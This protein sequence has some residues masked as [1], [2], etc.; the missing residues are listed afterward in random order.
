MNPHFLFRSNILNASTLGVSLVVMSSEEVGKTGIV[1]NIMR[2]NEM[3][4]DT[5]SDTQFLH[6]SGQPG[7]LLALRTQWICLLVVT[8]G[9]L[10]KGH[11]Y[12]PEGQ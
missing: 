1:I 6:A 4:R 12:E 5:C 3:R 8:Q 10:M 2:K 11:I 9:V 7:F